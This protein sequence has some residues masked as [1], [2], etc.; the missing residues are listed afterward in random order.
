MHFYFYFGFK[1]NYDTSNA[2]MVVLFSTIKFVEANNI[3]T[4][5]SL[6]ATS[7]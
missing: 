3:L 5:P 7:G 4:S 2:K 6:L 1:F